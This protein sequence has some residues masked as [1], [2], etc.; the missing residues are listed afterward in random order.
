[1]R[2]VLLL[3]NYRP[4]LGILRQIDPSRWRTILGRDGDV[5]QADRSNRVSEIWDHPHL[6]ADEPGFLAALTRLLDKR[7]DIAAILPVSERAT[8]ALNNIALPR[9]IAVWAPQPSVSAACV[10]KAELTRLAKRAGLSVPPYR[11][12]NRAHEVRMLANRIGYPCIAKPAAEAS[13]IAGEK[14]IVL[15][16]PE[17]ASRL[18]S[19]LAAESGPWILQRLVEGPRHNLY[20][21]ANGGVLAQGAEA[22]ITRT[23][24]PNGTGYAVTGRT[25]EPTPEIWAETRSLLKR[26][27]Y[28]GVGCAQFIRNPETGELCFLEINPRIGANAASVM[29]AGLDLVDWA[30]RLSGAEVLSMPARAD[31]YRRDFSYVWTKGDISGLKAAMAARSLTI[32]Q[33]ARWAGR[34][35]RDA[36]TADMHLTWSWR[37]PAPSLALYAQAFL[38]SVK[39]GRPKRKGYA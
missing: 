29:R 25:I 38:P 33:A 22:L 1:M 37:D 6:V 7:R 4:T 35:V 31:L 14:A 23:D 24:K 3:G 34:L 13:L 27:N 5:S 12:A 10:D 16:S 39:G 15:R 17:D 20:F 32:S 26:L 21:A 19:R 2:S 36:M 8:M 11:T 28:Q 18:R 30:E 9:R